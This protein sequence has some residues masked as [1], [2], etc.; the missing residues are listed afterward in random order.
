MDGV[1]EGLVAV[2]TTGC[3]M[4]FIW[5]GVTST[6]SML[7]DEALVEGLDSARAST[8]HSF[9][10]GGCSTWSSTLTNSVSAS[11]TTSSLISNLR[12]M[13]PS[14]SSSSS[15][16]LVEERPGECAVEEAPDE[17]PAIDRGPAGVLLV[18]HEGV[19]P[20]IFNFHVAVLLSESC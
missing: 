8:S 4:T 16:E 19:D 6:K 11:S 1:E 12:S 7:E 17:T 9:G 10:P 3:D 20:S 18:L 5:W 14:S 2:R 13:P 15:F